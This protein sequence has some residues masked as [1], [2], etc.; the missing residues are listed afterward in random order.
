MVAHELKESALQGKYLAKIELERLANRGNYEAQ[1]ELGIY[2]GAV[3]DYNKGCYWLDKLAV[4]VGRP[5]SADKLVYILSAMRNLAMYLNYLDNECADPRRAFDLY[6][7]I[8]NGY[9]NSPQAI[10]ATV[11]L[12]MMYYKDEYINYG[13]PHDIVKAKSLFAQWMKL[14]GTDFLHTAAVCGP[15]GMMFLK[16]GEMQ[17]AVFFLEKAVNGDY[18][19]DSELRIKQDY[20][21]AL[22][23]ARGY[24]LGK[25]RL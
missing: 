19:L 4:L 17:A 21:E 2:Y 1:Y 22:A 9:P 14:W 3:G 10:A 20:Q 24:S 25:D 12:G 6:W 11:E 15:L 5:A 16:N 8:K 18:Y 23:F 7:Q 13:I